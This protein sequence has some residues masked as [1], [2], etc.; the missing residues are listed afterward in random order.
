[1]RPVWSYWN[2]AR[3]TGDATVRRSPKPLYEITD[4]PASGSM[5]TLRRPRLS[6]NIDTVVTFWKGSAT[7]STRSNSAYV[8][9]V[10]SPAC[11]GAEEAVHTT[12][13]FTSRTT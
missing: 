2:F 4:V 12:R 7:V 9:F 10:A 5:S 11:A 3:F 8:N 1:M 6:Y 13:P